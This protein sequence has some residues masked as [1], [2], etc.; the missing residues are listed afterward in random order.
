MNSEYFCPKCGLTVSGAQRSSNKFCP[1]CGTFLRPKITRKPRRTAK[2]IEPLEL[3]RDD[4]NIHTLF[5]EFHNLKDFTCGEAIV[6]SDTYHWLIERRRA[7]GEFRERFRSLSLQSPDKIKEAFKHFLYFRN[8]KSWTTL[9]RKGKDA[10]QNPEGLGR[11]IASLLDESIDIRSRI[12]N[13]LIGTMHVAG[14][15]KNIVTAIVQVC[16]TQERYGVWNS[17]TEE[18]LKLLRRFPTLAPTP[19]ETYSRIN[20]E[21]NE[22]KIELKTGLMELDCF[23]WYIS[24]RVKV[25]GNPTS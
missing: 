20:R 4:I 5:Q 16:D 17:R 12:D 24:K 3:A 10:L 22:L 25:I 1:S 13:A 8:N 18:T 14:V 9:F 6:W 2:E 7:Y 11:L 21:L 19:G 23:M 15:G